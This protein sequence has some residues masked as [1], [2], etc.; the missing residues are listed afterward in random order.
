MAQFVRVTRP[1]TGIARLTIDRPEQRNALSIQVRDEMSEALEAL[2]SNDEVKV[3][4]IDSV[5][6]AFCAGFDLREFEDP[7]LSDRL[8][9]SSER[10]HEALRSHPLPLI[11]SVQGPAVAGGFDLATMCDLR[12]A[13]RGATFRR[14]ELAWGVAI[15]SILADLVGGAVARELSMTPRTLDA[16][17]AL[18]LHL[19]TRVVDDDQLAAATLELAREVAS[20]DRG[21]L[22]HAKAMAIAAAKH[23]P[24]GTWGW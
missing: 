9:A 14:P 16:P 21:A 4:V 17:E 20:L 7:D 13:A 2:A 8:W 10:W 5:G 11:A 15:Y 1:E 22:R 24:D 19:V 18:E 3:V 23:A 12:I 6:P